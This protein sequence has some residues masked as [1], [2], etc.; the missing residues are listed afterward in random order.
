LN[1]QKKSGK[2]TVFNKEIDKETARM[3]AVPQAKGQQPIA[4]GQQ[5]QPIAKG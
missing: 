3:G 5:Q 2:R 4:K 1:N